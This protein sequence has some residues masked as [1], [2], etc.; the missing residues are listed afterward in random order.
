[1]NGSHLDNVRYKP[2]TQ[3]SCIDLLTVYM[4]LR[5]ASSSVRNY[6]QHSTQESF[7]ATNQNVFP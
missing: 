5:N 1:M 6:P 2:I 3:K 4:R 7:W